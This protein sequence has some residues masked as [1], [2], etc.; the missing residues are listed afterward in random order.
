R[1]RVD[2]DL[3]DTAANGLNAGSAGMANALDQIRCW[4]ARTL[5]LHVPMIANRNRRAVVEAF[6]VS[7]DLRQD[8]AE[9]ISDGDDAS[10]IKLR[11][12]DVQ[13]I[14]DA[15]VGH[16]SL[17]NVE[18]GQF[19][20]LFNPQPTLHEQFQKGPIPERVHLI[21]PRITARGCDL[22]RRHRSFPLLKGKGA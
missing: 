16:L 8:S 2:R 19:A 14:I 12:L 1:S 17:E 15:A 11:R 18:R 7:D 6:Y 22:R 21:G 13:E 4:R 10:T 9:P 3:A 20:R 5:L